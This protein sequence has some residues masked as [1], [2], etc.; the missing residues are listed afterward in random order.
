MDMPP[1][2]SCKAQP[3]LESSYCAAYVT[4]GEQRDPRGHLAERFGVCAD[5]FTSPQD[6][7]PED[8]ELEADLELVTIRKASKPYIT[9]VSDAGQLQGI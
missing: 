2:L 9:H 8:A 6:G 7:M 4:L 5:G 1:Y 3:F